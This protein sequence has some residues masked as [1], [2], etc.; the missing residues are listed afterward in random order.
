LSRRRHKG[1]IGSLQITVDERGVQ[2]IST[3]AEMPKAA[4]PMDDKQAVAALGA[5]AQEH[6]LQLFRLL[7]PCGPEGLPAGI[8]AERLGVPPSSLSFH[9]GQLT[10][11]GLVTQ[12]R[13]GRQLF[14][15]AVFEAMN[16]LVAYLA[17]NS[18][19]PDAAA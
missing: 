13:S 5:L 6:R 2:G 7:V 18:C 10:Q 9:L 16:D 17:E 15:A 8:I 19:A 12:R 4:L 3:S 1:W 14:Y 11:A